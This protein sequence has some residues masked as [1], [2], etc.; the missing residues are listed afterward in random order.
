[1]HEQIYDQSCAQI[2]IKLNNGELAL[3]IYGKEIL[4]H[5]GPIWIQIVEPHSLKD[6]ILRM[7][8]HS[9]LA[10]HPGGHKLHNK[11]QKDLNR[12]SLGVC[13]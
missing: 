8:H 4:V 13:C 12:R 1:M 6:R 3:G 10:N 7:K 11:M 5:T 9:L 2:H